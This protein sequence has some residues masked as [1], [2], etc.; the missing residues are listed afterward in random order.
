MLL[1]IV[2]KLISTKKMAYSWNV[3]KFLRSKMQICSIAMMFECCLFCSPMFCHEDKP[4]LVEVMG[5]DPSM[6]MNGVNLVK[7][8][9][10][11]WPA[12]LAKSDYPLL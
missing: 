12:E 2:V 11:T 4:G 6:I 1:P 9:D 7:P 3:G 8:R 10:E 5:S